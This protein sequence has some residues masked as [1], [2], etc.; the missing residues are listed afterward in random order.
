M[1]KKLKIKQVKSGIGALKKHKATLRALKLT[2]HQS[3]TVHD[4]TP[5]IR[6]MISK[7]CHL[8]EVEEIK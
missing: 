4:D 6:G 8:V 1:K 3:S 2:R 5:Q 7:V